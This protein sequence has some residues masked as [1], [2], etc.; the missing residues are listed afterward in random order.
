MTFIMK[1]KQL[2]A[3]LR[4]PV[5]GTPHVEGITFD[6]VTNIENATRFPSKPY[7]LSKAGEKQWA[8]CTVCSIGKT[9]GD[10]AIAEAEHPKV[11]GKTGDLVAYLG[12]G[13][14]INGT[15]C[16]KAHV[17]MAYGNIQA[18]SRLT[19][20]TMP[21]I[22]CHVVDVLYWD[23]ADLTVIVVGN[24]ND[25][26][27]KVQGELEAAGFTYDHQFEPH[28]TIGKGDIVDVVRAMLG[29]QSSVLLCNPF[30]QIKER[31]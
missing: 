16:E 15:L 12:Y 26:L 11:V 19:F 8:A 3:Y 22:A 1:D 29:N 13:A 17:T 14:E 31:K 20:K 27:H 25:M 21:T 7:P 28:I 9:T 5:G 10:E 2:K 18:T 24:K 4:Q 30:I 23:K 6:L